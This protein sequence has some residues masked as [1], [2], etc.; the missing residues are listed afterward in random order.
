MADGVDDETWNF[1]LRQRD[2]SRWIKDA[3]KD[4]DLAQQVARIETQRLL[5]KDSRAHIRRAISEKYTNAA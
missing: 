5:P 1:H 4:D 2:Y 3:I